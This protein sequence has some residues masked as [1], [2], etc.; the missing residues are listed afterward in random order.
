[1]A[2][3]FRDFCKPFLGICDAVSILFYYTKYTLRP[4]GGLARRVGCCYPGRR[5]LCCGVLVVS[6]LY[7]P[8]PV[9]PPVGGP[10]RRVGWVLPPYVGTDSAVVYQQNQRIPGHNPS[11][12]SRWSSQAGWVGS[13]IKVGV[14]C[15]I[16][17]I[18]DWFHSWIHRHNP[19]T[20]PVGDP[21]QAGWVGSIIGVGVDYA[22]VHWSNRCF[23]RHYPSHRPVGDPGQA[24]LGGFYLPVSVSIMLWLMRSIL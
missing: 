11:P 22:V 5:R 10:A 17:R 13:T 8:S 2:S 20:W 16:G 6:Q 19:S 24:G 15:S 12:A 9:P 1:M 18:I 7:F 21:G 3:F 23:H 4:V 14:V